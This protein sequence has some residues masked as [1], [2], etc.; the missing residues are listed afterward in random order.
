MRTLVI[1]TSGST[2]AK[3]KKKI[4]P[5]LRFSVPAVFRTFY[6]NYPGEG[7]GGGYST[8]F[9]TG[10]LRLEVQPLTLLNE[11]GTP[12]VYLPLTNGIPFTYFV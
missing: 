1:F 6:F 4:T 9:Y 11:K 8:N 2:E 7:E 10:R 3:K 5:D 12:F